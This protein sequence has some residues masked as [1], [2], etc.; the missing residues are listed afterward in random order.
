MKI[1]ESKLNEHTGSSF[2]IKKTD[3]ISKISFSEKQWYIN[4]DNYAEAF[5]GKCESCK[6]SDCRVVDFTLIMLILPQIAV[7]N[8]CRKMVCS[9]CIIHGIDLAFGI[10]NN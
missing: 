8:E 2:T 9:I 5:L 4:E 1:E 3:G 10:L 7:V 6:N